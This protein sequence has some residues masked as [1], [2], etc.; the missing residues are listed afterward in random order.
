M[1]S[2]PKTVEEMFERMDAEK[3]YAA[4]DPNEYARRVGGRIDGP[5]RFENLV[6]GRVRMR[7]SIVFDE[8]NITPM[9]PTTVVAG[10]TRNQRK[11]D[12]QQRR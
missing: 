8:P 10:R 1:P 4:I 9:H 11:R 2:P 12:R 3:T 6:N 5:L 7:G